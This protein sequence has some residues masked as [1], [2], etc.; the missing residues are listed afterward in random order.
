MDRSLGDGYYLRGGL[1]IQISR[2]ARQRTPLYSYTAKETRSVSASEVLVVG[3][4]CGVALGHSKICSRMDTYLIMCDDWRLMEEHPQTICQQFERFLNSEVLFF[5]PVLF[6]EYSCLT[7]FVYEEIDLV[8][9]NQE[10]LRDAR[11]SQDDFIRLWSWQDKLAQKVYH[12]SGG[13]RKLLGLSLFL[14]RKS[15][16]L[17]FIDFASQLADTTIAFALE[18]MQ[19]LNIKRVG[20]VEY[21]EAVIQKHLKQCKR[22]KQSGARL[23]E[24]G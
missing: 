9:S 13:W 22:L 23:S 21:D 15:D 10:K 24:V 18:R 12:L 2:D 20:F 16:N 17:L 4:C 1:R 6:A 5:A 11:I 8:V 3:S 7:Q 19:Q 14:N